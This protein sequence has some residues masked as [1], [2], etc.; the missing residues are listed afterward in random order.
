MNK[1]LP[2]GIA[3]LVG[4]ALGFT[5]RSNKAQVPVA[6]APVQQ[7]V[8]AQHSMHAVMDGMTASLEGKTGDAFD[9]AF[10]DEMIVHHQG[11]IDMAEQVLATSTRPELR[12]LAEA[13]IAAQS[14]EIKMMQ[15]WLSTWYTK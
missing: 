5:F 12:T 6:Q 4:I 10:L 13:I 14:T 7:E 2:V 15:D 1:Y 9:Q 8:P 3:L 11:A